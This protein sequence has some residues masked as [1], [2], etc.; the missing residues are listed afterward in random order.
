MG[1][2]E[3][4]PIVYTTVRSELVTDVGGLSRDKFEPELNTIFCNVDSVYWFVV[5]GDSCCKV[6]IKQLGLGCSRETG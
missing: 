6:P 2:L 4:G 1:E 3:T 5:L